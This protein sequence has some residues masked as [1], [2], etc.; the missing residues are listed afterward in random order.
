E[1]DGSVKYIQV[2]G[3]ADPGNSGGAA[4]ATNGN[5]NAV[6]VAGDSRTSMRWVIPSEYVMHLLHGRVLMMMPRQAVASGGTIKQPFTALIADPLKRLK[7]VT[8]EFWV[9][10]PGKVRPAPAS[11]QPQMAAGDGER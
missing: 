1:S 10:K 9:G 5:V 11:G 7:K 2:E 3:G 8:G 4:V 6:L